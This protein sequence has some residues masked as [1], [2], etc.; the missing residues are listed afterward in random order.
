MKAKTEWSCPDCIPNE[1]V[2]LNVMTQPS[3]AAVEVMSK[4]K[5]PLVVVGAGGKMGP[6]LCLLAK[7]AAEEAGNELSVIAVSR[8][9]NDAEREWLEAYGIQTQR[10]DTLEPSDVGRLPEASH[11]IFL[12]G[13]KFGTQSNPD[14]TWATNTLAPANIARRYRQVPMVA[15][16]TGN[17]YPLVPANSA[18]ATEGD[19]LTPLG[20]YANAAVARE[21]VFGYFSRS[22]GIPC[23]VLRLNYALDLR[24]GILVDLARSILSDQAID[25]SMSRVNCLWQGDANDFILRSL[26]LATSPAATFNM[27]SPEVYEVKE[28]A[29]KLGTHV[30]KSVRFTGSP[31]E[32]ALLSD[33]TALTQRLGAP[34]T[35]IDSVIKWTAEWMLAGGR[36]LGRPTK[37]QVRDGRF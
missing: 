24:Y 34:R 25:L 17:V 9:S 16:S 23:V 4:V 30:N 12:V 28:L 29:T 15:L 6:S 37:F 21:R 11:L 10:C 31:S 5:G 2:L 7:R 20:E 3:A 26:E 18:G 19:P 1:D 8:F 35:P 32:T 33:A 36:V 14:L 27:T 13:L 22:L